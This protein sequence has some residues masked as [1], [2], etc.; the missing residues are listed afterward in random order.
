MVPLTERRKIKDQG[1]NKVSGEIEVKKG[2][3]LNDNCFIAEIRM[4]G[5]YSDK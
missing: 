2:F 4:K 1:R 3:F 5:V